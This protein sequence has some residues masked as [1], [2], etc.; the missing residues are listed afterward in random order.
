[1]SASLSAKLAAPMTGG[2]FGRSVKRVEDARLVRGKGR[3]VD[4]MALGGE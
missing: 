4:D 3:F 2:S 1:M